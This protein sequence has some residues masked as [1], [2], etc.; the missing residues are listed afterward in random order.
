MT[1]YSRIDSVDVQGRWT[2]QS[3]ISSGVVLNE[4]AGTLRKVVDTGQDKVANK[5]KRE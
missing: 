5:G 2:L 4:T 3:F 1:N